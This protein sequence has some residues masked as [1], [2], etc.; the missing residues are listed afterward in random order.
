MKAIMAWNSS[1]VAGSD[2]IQNSNMLTE[3]C[4][5]MTQNSLCVIMKIMPGLRTFTC[6]HKATIWLGSL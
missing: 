6:W 3:R 1:A 2:M 4:Y 5:V